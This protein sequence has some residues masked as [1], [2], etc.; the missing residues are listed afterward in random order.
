MVFRKVS[1]AQVKFHPDRMKPDRCDPTVTVAIRETSPE[2]F[3][4]VRLEAGEA[5]IALRRERFETKTKSKER[6]KR[7]KR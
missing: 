4:K 2:T 5:V 7:G 6:A 3:L 1:E